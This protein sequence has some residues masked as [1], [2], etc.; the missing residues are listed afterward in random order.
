ML[1]L[2][3]RLT[4]YLFQWHKP[5]ILSHMLFRIVFI[6]AIGVFAIGANSNADAGEL[7]CAKLF[8]S[9]SKTHWVNLT[10]E[11]DLEYLYGLK[12]EFILGRTRSGSEIK[13][14]VI[15]VQSGIVIYESRNGRRMIAVKEIA[16]LFVM[17]KVNERRLTGNPAID[18]LPLEDIKI[19]SKRKFWVQA[20]MLKSRL[21]EAFTRQS[22]QWKP[23]TKEHLNTL[24]GKYIAGFFFD[25]FESR[26]S[27]FAGRIVGFRNSS[28]EGSNPFYLLEIDGPLGPLS[29]PFS[30]GSEM[31][32]LLNE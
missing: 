30:S 11:P 8:E 4:L 26:V 15:K 14:R 7:S 24:V 23:L 9:S 29:I 32:H 19:Y 16:E 6:V 5:S 20:N 27:A 12:N 31:L 13:G 3:G 25:V 17:T 1:I 10:A 21:T 22:K 18:L 2:R 28:P